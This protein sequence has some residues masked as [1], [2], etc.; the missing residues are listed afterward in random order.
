MPQQVLNT[1]TANLQPLTKLNVRI[2]LNRK[3]ILTLDA[4]SSL[5]WFQSVLSLPRSET[6]TVALSKQASQTVK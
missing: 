1:A 2:A 6:A 4:D 5:R 3:R